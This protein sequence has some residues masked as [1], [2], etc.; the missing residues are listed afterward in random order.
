MVPRPRCV[1][2]RRP[3][4]AARPEMTSG[5]VPQSVQSV[6][7]VSRDTRAIHILWRTNECVEARCV[8]YPHPPTVT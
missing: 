7:A 6:P 2:R 3:D 4:A 5:L 1:C 8:P